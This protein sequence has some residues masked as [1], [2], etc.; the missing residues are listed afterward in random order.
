[1]SETRKACARR[2]GDAFFLKYCK[3]K[4]I[5]IGCGNDPIQSDQ[6][7]LDV[8]AFDHLFGH[9]DAQ[10]MR[11]QQPASFDWVYSSHTLEHMHDPATALQNWWR[12]LKP[13]GYLILLLPER[14]L[15]EKRTVLPSRWNEDHKYYFLLDRD[16]KPHT[17][18][19]VPLVSRVC[20]PGRIQEARTLMHEPFPTDP[21]KHS[22]GE[23]SIELV[24]KKLVHYVV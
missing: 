3:G 7:E 20:K 16:E 19:L 2:E 6:V 10:F 8:F 17:L 21:T 18:G 15:Y 24:T 12:I 1:M 23:Y 11:H 22:D 4:G 13:G 9:G 14:D 5:D